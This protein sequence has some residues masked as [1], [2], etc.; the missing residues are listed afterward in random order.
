MVQ[1]K[2]CIL[3]ILLFGFSLGC[4]RSGADISQAYSDI[5]NIAA[6][7]K[8][9]HMMTGQLP[10]T[11]QGLAALTK[12]PD[13]LPADSKWVMSFKKVP[14]DPWGIEYE[15]TLLSTDGDPKF[16]IRSLGQDRIRSEDDIE[17]TY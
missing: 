3:L 1:I 9:Y 15:Y 8:S 12:R 17:S 2:R 13:D 10:T 4:R 5:M 14:T 16:E 6:A 7:V 11:E